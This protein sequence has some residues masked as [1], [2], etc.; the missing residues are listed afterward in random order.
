MQSKLVKCNLILMKSTTVEP[1]PPIM[2]T[3]GPDIFGHFLLTGYS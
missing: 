2:D 3:L 1:D